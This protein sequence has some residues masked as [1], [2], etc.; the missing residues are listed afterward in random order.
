VP[1]ERDDIAISLMRCILENEEKKPGFLSDARITV[2]YIVL[3]RMVLT[4]PAEVM[5]A[6]Q[7]METERQKA[8]I[9]EYCRANSIA[10]DEFIRYPMSLA[11]KVEDIAGRL[12]A[13][14]CLVIDTIADLGESLRECLRVI[15]KLVE[16]R[17]GLVACKE[18]IDLRSDGE[19]ARAVASLL[20]HLA[21]TTR[22][23]LT[24]R[25]R[26]S[27]AGRK[28]LGCRVGRPRGKPGKSVLDD[29]KDEIIRYLKKRVPKTA[30]ARLMDVNRATLFNY[31]KSHGLEEELKGDHEKGE[32]EE[33]LAAEG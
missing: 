12:Q 5:K 11:E 23:I 13:G 21:T 20:K 6:I 8:G 7:D 24:R 16:A 9:D 19:T 15:D 4:V 10:I 33:R 17:I 25:N 26:I 30:I 14:D 22:T 29:R 2:A 31:V 28:A 32:G 1:P 3:P 27:V 18:K